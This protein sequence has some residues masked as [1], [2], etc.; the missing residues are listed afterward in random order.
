MVLARFGSGV[1]LSSLLDS[2]SITG[3]VLATFV[4]WCVFLDSIFMPSTAAEMIVVVDVP[5]LS[6]IVVLEVGPVVVMVVTTVGN[7]AADGTAAGTGSLIVGVL[8]GTVVSSLVGRTRKSSILCKSSLVCY[9]VICFVCAIG[10]ISVV[11]GEGTVTSAG[12][13]GRGNI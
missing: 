12:T 5:V 3:W 8:V 6:I 4:V 11:V 9:L 10:W 2:I 1:T 7:S 13:I